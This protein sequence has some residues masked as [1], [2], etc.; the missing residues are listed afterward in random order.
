VRVYETNALEL[1]D[2]FGQLGGQLERVVQADGS[3]LRPQVLSIRFQ[4]QPSCQEI[5]D[6]PAGAI[7]LAIYVSITDY[8]AAHFVFLI[9]DLSDILSKAT[10]RA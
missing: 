3:I 1:S 10:R 5:Q 9:A 7:I 8:Q 6:M 2:E 4:S